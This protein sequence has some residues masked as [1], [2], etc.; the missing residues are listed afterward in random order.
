MVPWSSTQSHNQLSMDHSEGG[1]GDMKCS[2]FH[3]VSSPGYRI[4]MVC[5]F[6]NIAFCV[7]DICNIHYLETINIVNVNIVNMHVL[8]S[9][10]K[11]QKIS[12]S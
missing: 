12:L 7:L 10:E 5:R 1:G 2:A 8:L 4:L 11:T 9:E 3:T 6:T